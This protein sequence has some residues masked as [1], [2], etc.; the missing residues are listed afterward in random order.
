MPFTGVASSRQRSVMTEVLDEFCSERS[1]SPDS[2][3]RAEA[4]RLIF[5]L[6][7]NGWRTPAELKL[8]L[9]W[10]KPQSDRGD[11]PD[12]HAA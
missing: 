1:I 8:A 10:A 7:E 9:S 3:E 4:T 6:L 2:P 5:M 11:N 12:R